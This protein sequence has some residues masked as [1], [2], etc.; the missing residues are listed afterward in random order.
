MTHEHNIRGGAGVEGGGVL[1]VAIHILHLQLGTV[2]HYVCLP[3][4]RVTRTGH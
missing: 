3:S 4:I 2:G 1:L